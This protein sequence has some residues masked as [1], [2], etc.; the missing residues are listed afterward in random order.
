MGTAAAAALLVEPAAA[1]DRVRLPTEIDGW[2][3]GVSD[4]LPMV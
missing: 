3:I 2:S 1:A 4:G